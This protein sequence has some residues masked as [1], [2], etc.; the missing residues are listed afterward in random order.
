MTTAAASA[1]TA[2]RRRTTKRSD[3]A[4]ETAEHAVD[5]V[6]FLACGSARAAS[7]TISGGASV[8]DRIA[9]ANIANVLVYA[10][11]RNSRPAW[12]ASVKIGRKLTV[13]SS[14]EKKIGRPTS[15]QASMMM[16]L[17]SLPGGAAARRTCA[18]SISTMAASASSPIAIAMPPSDMMF[19]VR[20]R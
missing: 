16:R 15:L 7:S 14:S 3:R 2:N 17:R 18:F 13:M 20:P 6:L 19:E 4:I 8:I 9:A 10:S 11:G 1:T 5:R 12:P